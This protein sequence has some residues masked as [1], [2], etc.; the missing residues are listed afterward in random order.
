[1]GSFMSTLKVMHVDLETRSAVDLKKVGAHRY[2]EDPTTAIVCGSA[3]FGEG[4]VLS[5]VG[6]ALPADVFHHLARHGQ[7]VG[8]NQQ[9]ERVILN[10][11]LRLGIEPEDQD[12]TMARA[13]AMGL[14]HSL[15]GVGTALNL[16]F[17]KDKQGH[18]LMLKMCKPRT[19][20]PLTWHDDPD[21][22]ARLSAYC[23]RDVLTEADADRH[24]PPLSERERRVWR[25]DQRINDRGFAVD[26]RAVQAAYDCVAGAQRDADRRLWELTDGA[27]A[28]VS[29]VK[30]LVD[31][32]GSQGVHC[33]SVAD[34]EIDDLI[35]YS[36][37]V[38]KP[39]AEAAVRL[40]RVS[41]GAFKFEAMLRAVCAD[42]RI[43]GC[44]Q[45]HGTHGGRWA[46]RVVQP[47]NFKR[48]D[49]DDEA[50]R[51]QKALWALEQS[52]P[53]EA[54]R[55]VDDK[56]LEVLTLCA[57][58][59]IVAPSGKKL[60]DADFS[61]IEGRVCAWFADAW[62]KLEAFRK[63]D[64]KEGP[65]IYRVNA[66]D[67]LEK[68]IEDVTAD[69]RQE[70]GKVGELSG[71]FQ[72]GKRAVQKKAREFGIEMS[73]A[74]AMR[75]INGW[76]ATNVEIVNMWPVLQQAAIDAV[77]APGVQVSILGD[78]IR[79]VCNGEF[80][81]C[82]LPSGRVISYARPKVGWKRKIIDADG[83]K[84]EFDSYGLSF[85]GQKNGRWIEIDAYGGMLCAHI[86]S[87]TARDVLVEAM[88]AVEA[89][90][91][92]IILTVHDEI[93]CEVDEG[94]GSAT[95]F[96]Q[97]ILANRPEWVAGLPLVCKAWADRRYSK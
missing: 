77:Q 11:R 38:G 7:M 23:D 24:L 4:P 2:A 27:V 80:L 92:P 39:N 75:I 50:E 56:P 54:L 29:Q 66:A 14:P 74:K 45:Y 37:L 76:R 94:F 22:L 30:R 86:V 51:V 44:L 32:L 61:N 17:Q 53:L 70:I 95:D 63:F 71:Q 90:G 13:A 85:W 64:R 28:K 31:W 89:A 93:L 88:F 47:H 52:E 82:R 67:T 1:M 97:V 42:G 34:S 6:E 78:R 84:I 33:E 35:V 49:T 9:F 91:Y 81:F 21:E 59:M 19:R 18:A 55:L 15:E 48:I 40:R 12:C 43:R 68:P 16:K 69:E 62:W 8:H 96:E 83:E 10:A 60:V 26:L 46:G 58:P 41:A 5:W 3:R 65:D 79:Y 36:E 57:R 72:G 87:G 20:E 73:D 25:L